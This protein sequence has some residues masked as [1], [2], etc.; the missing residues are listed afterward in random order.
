MCLN[1]K[2][3]SGVNSE[4]IIIAENNVE[5]WESPEMKGAWGTHI[6]TTDSHNGIQRDTFGFVLCKS[7]STATTST[8]LVHA[9]PIESPRTLILHQ[10]DTERHQQ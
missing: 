4:T 1:T 7:G 9:E 8:P 10:P 5:C 6:L 3:P 2:I